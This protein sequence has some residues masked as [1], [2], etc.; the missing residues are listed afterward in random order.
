MSNL[1]ETSSNLAKF[2]LKLNPKKCAFGVKSK[3]ILGF[4]TFERSI[5]VN[6]KK[7]KW[8]HNSWNLGA[9]GCPTL[10]RMYCSVRQVHF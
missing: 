1:E 4:I 6:P 9:Q 7:L 2:D 8:L 3:K 10:K 5:E